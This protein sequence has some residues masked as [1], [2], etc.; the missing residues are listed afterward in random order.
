MYSTSSGNAHN[1]DH[2]WYLRDPVGPAK[3][4]KY[5]LAPFYKAF[6][7]K[8]IPVKCPVEYFKTHFMS[9]HGCAKCDTIAWYFLSLV[10]SIHLYDNNYLWVFSEN[11]LFES[12][13]INNYTSNKI[14]S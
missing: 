12:E 7:K 5:G 10:N 3:G 4:W 8:N 2:L 6:S 11:Y 13:R 14:I 1:V 9:L